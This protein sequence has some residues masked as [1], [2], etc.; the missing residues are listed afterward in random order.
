[1]WLYVQAIL[2]AGLIL[3]ALAVVSILRRRKE[4]L[5]ML[6]WLFA[7]VFLPVIGVLL[8]WL[9]SS[10]RIRRKASR[11]RRRATALVSQL[12]RALESRLQAG[13]DE[14]RTRLPEDLRPVERMAYRLS[15]FPAVGGNDVRVY[16]EANQTYAA[17]EEAI[18][19]ARHH[20]HLEYYIW[21]PDETG[22][23]FRD[24][25]IEKARAGVECRLLL[26]ALGCSRL[27]QRFIRPLTEGGVRLAFYMPFYPFRKGWSFHLRNHRKIAVMDG[28]TAFIGSQNIGDE[29][30]GRLKKLSPWY[31][32]HMRVA[33]PAA[34]FLQLTF[35]E[36]WAFSTRERLDG[37]QYCPDPRQ[38]GESIVQILPT[39]PDQD[40]N[41]LGHIVF[42]AV[43]L[44]K[45]N[46][47]IATPYFVP[48]AETLIA[49]QYA[50]LRG[51]R[52]QIV[53]P[54]RSDAPLALW[55]GRSFYND[56]MQAGVEIYEYDHG[57]LHSKLITI[58]NR[59]C[60]LGSANM[61]VR[62]FRLNFEVTALVYDPK[63]AD[64]SSDSIERRCQRARRIAPPDVY[65]GSLGRELLEGAARLFAP[66]L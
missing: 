32:S 57:V 31:D 22:R 65:H 3:S 1:M 33:G 11:R 36:D 41:T 62:S 35:F 60:M 66:L 21:Q 27:N 46:I 30:R 37:P 51:V 45:E 55:A 16:E 47:R 18:R 39:G 64:E 10:N 52:V 17:L 9:F 4:P 26:D 29:Y 63:V 38:A 14:T 56:L 58:D 59:W 23:Y 6:A 40:V 20:I 2:L 13:S 43:S 12:N 53:L 28:Q 48:N 50:A 25:L 5:A 24:L 34:L 54:T 15:N 61:D 7:V 8:Y 19:A 44:A 42:A 49:L